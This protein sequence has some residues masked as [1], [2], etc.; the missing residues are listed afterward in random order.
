MALF[1][2]DDDQLQSLINEGASLS[3]EIRA[4]SEN[5]AKWQAA[6]NVTLKAGFAALITIFGGDDPDQ[7]QARIDQF[8]SAIADEADALEGA[9]DKDQQSNT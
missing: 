3:Q 9:A 6:Q 1:R 8:T 7:V 4:L 5:L 2:L